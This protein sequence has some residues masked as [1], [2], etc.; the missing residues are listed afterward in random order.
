MVS[1]F[2]L[3][4]QLNL[5]LAVRSYAY[6][7]RLKAAVR[8]AVWCKDADLQAIGGFHLCQDGNAVYLGKQDGALAK[9]PFDLAESAESGLSSLHIDASGMYCPV[10][11]Y[12]TH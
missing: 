5:K 11:K 10:K 12:L 2:F 8:D 6:H 4:P 9:R 7:A 1:D 3:S